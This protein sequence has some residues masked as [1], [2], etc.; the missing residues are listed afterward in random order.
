MS[1]INDIADPGSPTDGQ[2]HRLAALADEGKTFQARCDGV[3]ARE[4]LAARARIAKQDAMLAEFVWGEDNPAEYDTLHT[5]LASA[6]EVVDAARSMVRYMAY[7]RR[8]HAE[9]PDF[10]ADMTPLALCRALAAYDK[11][12]S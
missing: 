4:L 12:G 5:R 11:V 9:C 10:Q 2:L 1:E 8:T 7:P 6:R 3:I